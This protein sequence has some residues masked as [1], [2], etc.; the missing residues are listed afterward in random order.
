[1]FVDL[2]CHSP[3]VAMTVMVL[4]CMILA[5]LILKGGDTDVDGNDSNGKQSIKGGDE[6]EEGK[7]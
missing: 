4:I 7:R 5:G 2:I 3:D 6:I 1:M